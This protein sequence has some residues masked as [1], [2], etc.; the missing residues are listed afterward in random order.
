MVGRRRN[1]RNLRRGVARPCNLLVDLLARQ[2][3]ALTRL[4]PLRHLD[5]Q[6][7]GVRQIADGH[8]KTPRSHLADATGTALA[9]RIRL[10]ALRTFA[11][12]A[13]VAKAADAVHRHRNGLMC[14]GT[15][16]PQ[17]H[18]T[19]NKM[20]KHALNRLNLLQWN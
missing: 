11:S 2:L 7:L 13:R 10:V 14:L 5:L 8:A 9:R 4:R 18:R 19:T 17:A 15:Q 16:C 3:A 20:V 1:Q 12:F 6:V